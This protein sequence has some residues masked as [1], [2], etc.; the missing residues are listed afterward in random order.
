MTATNI[1][2]GAYLAHLRDKADFKQN[3]IAQKVGW[4]PAVLSR[5]ESGERALS[6]T[7]LDSILE[8]I[9]SEQALG[10]QGN[11]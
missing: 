9:G 7:E 5:V 10:V 3:E 4:S 6:P 1:E 11:S 8:A 2:I